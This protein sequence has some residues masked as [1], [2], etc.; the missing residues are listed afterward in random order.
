[1]GRGRLLTGA[2]GTSKA[3]TSVKVLG[4]NLECPPEVHMLKAWFT[5]HGATG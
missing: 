5:A 3:G 1:M 4:V 2:G